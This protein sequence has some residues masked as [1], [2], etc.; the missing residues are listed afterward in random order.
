MSDNAAHTTRPATGPA[1]G[2]ADPAIHPLFEPTTCTWQYV[3]ADPST[4]TA[5][6]I[7][8]VLD[9]DNSTRTVSTGTPDSLLSLV[10]SNGYTVSH[11]LET[12]AHADHLT[13]AFYLQRRLAAE[14]GQK[15]PVGI[16][17]RIGRVQSLF[18][19]RYGVPSDEYDGV[20]DLLL[21]DNEVFEIGSLKAE[22]IHLPGHTPDHM[23]YRIGGM[24]ST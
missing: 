12:H 17:A 7:D 24:F 2:Q 10:R 19:K 3:V 6:I 13:A 8:P 22:A 16:G 1:T 4:K 5:A 23:G 20:F 15:P 9:Y 18:G 11:I 14:Q 21:G